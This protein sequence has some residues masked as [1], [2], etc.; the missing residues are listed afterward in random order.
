MLVNIRQRPPTFGSAGG[1]VIDPV[2]V[3]LPL[4]FFNKEVPTQDKVGS[5]NLSD[6]L[7]VPVGAAEVADVL[8][9]K[10]EVLV[11]TTFGLLQNF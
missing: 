4:N 8:V 5:G 2:V 7:P 6:L 3:T 9:A 10:V 11:D 1:L